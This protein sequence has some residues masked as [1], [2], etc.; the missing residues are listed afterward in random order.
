ML[1]NEYE[2]LQLSAKSKDDLDVVSAC[3]QDAI[4]PIKGMSFDDKKSE[5]YLIANRFCWE[6]HPEKHDG[7]E[8][9]HRIHSGIY[10]AGVNGVKSKGFDFG[11]ATGIM[12]L[13][14]IEATDNKHIALH[15]SG[16]A[17]VI[18]EINSIHCLAKDLDEQPYPSHIKPKHNVN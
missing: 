12:N 11:H 8:H 16:G 9:H 6:C 14:G 4:V 3:F 17:E 1:N 2:T 7:E 13:L 18:L 10:F 5:F 15:F